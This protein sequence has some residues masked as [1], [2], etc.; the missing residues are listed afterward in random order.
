MHCMWC[1]EPVMWSWRGVWAHR[2]GS[3]ADHVVHPA[4]QY[5]RNGLTLWSSINDKR[6]Y[7]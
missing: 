2:L 6:N 3:L 1:K 5:E 7:V 4:R